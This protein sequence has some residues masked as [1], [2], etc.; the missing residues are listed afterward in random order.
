MLC[1]LGKFVDNQVLTTTLDLLTFTM[2]ISINKLEDR[3][4]R[5]LDQINVSSQPETSKDDQ[6]VGKLKKAY[7]EIVRDIYNTTPGALWDII[8]VF[9]PDIWIEIVK[10]SL[11]TEGY[12]SALL[13]LTLVSSKWHRILVSTPI[14]WTYI[15]ICGDHSDAMATINTFAYLSRNSDLTLII[16]VPLRYDSAIF[17]PILARMTGRIKRI[18]FLPVMSAEE[19]ALT[20]EFDKTCYEDKN[21]IMAWPNYLSTVTEIDMVGSLSQGMDATSLM[22][23][24][25]ILPLIKRLSKWCFH[26]DDLDAIFR[27]APHLEE[28]KTCMSRAG[29]IPCFTGISQIRSIN[30]NEICWYHH[31]Y[32]SILPAQL[33]VMSNLTKFSFNG[34]FKTNIIELVSSVAVTLLDLELHLPYS[35]CSHLLHIL[36]HAKRLTRLSLTL[37]YEMVLDRDCTDELVTLEALNMVHSVPSLRELCWFIGYHLAGVAD[38]LKRQLTK[39]FGRLYPMVEKAYFRDYT[40]DPIAYLVDYLPHLQNLKLLSIDFKTKSFILSEESILQL[41]SLETLEVKGSS[42]LNHLEAPELHHLKIRVE[43]DQIL[44][45][46]NSAGLRSLYLDDYINKEHSIDIPEVYSMVLT[47]LTLHVLFHENVV[48]KHI[49][50]SP[51]TVLS[52]FTQVNTATT[53]SLCAALLYHPEACP[54]LETIRFLNSAPEWDILFMMLERRNFRKGIARIRRLG[55][56]FLPYHLRGPLC[57]LLRGMYTNRPSNMELSFASAIDLYWDKNM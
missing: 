29:F 22:G 56:P 3:R 51:L 42:L 46:I 55:L 47:T 15:E 19:F 7:N 25:Q 20:Q 30:I 49:S 11:P 14:L 10:Q 16:K 2:S 40:K 6:T 31:G 18:S 50:F 39:L 53:T 28:V 35:G 48:M 57:S 52:I 13:T 34:H 33:P 9:P 44:K 5:I 8:E 38:T 17:D 1:Q 21:V 41:K 27:I 37:Y 4:L 23:I 26:T 32:E 36:G 54:A 43:T 24:L 12:A 45:P